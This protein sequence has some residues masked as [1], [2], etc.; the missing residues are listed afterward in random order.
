MSSRATATRQARTGRSTGSRSTTRHWTT[1]W[2]DCCAGWARRASYEL[3]ARDAVDELRL[4]VFPVLLGEG[5][6]LFDGVSSPRRRRPRRRA[7]W[8]GCGR[9]AGRS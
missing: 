9:S 8:P 5:R 4:L 6:R 3:P 7:D 1:T 2:P